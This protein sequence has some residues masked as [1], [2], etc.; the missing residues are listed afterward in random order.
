M[1]KNN[2]SYPLSGAG[3][4]WFLGKQ[5]ALRLCHIGIVLLGITFLSFSLLHMAPGDPAEKYLTGGDG[6]V[7]LISEEAIQA[8]R[9]KWGLD[10]PFLVQ[11][12]T[13]LGNALRG[14]L[15]ESFA[16]GNPVVTELWD[17]I[18][19]TVILALASLFVTLLVS[20]PLGVLCAVYKDR[21]L[22]N[23][24][25]V[26]SFVGISVPSFL[27]SLLLLYFFAMKLQWFPVISRGG[28][29][30]LVLPVAVLAFQCSAK[31]TRQV[32][33][34]VLEQL[35]QEYV[36]GAVARGV[37]KSRILFDH[38]LRNAW[39]PIVTWAGIYFGVFLGGAAVVETVFSWQGIGQLAVE[40]VASKDYQMIQ[41][42]VLWMAVLYLAVNFLVDISYTFLDP[43]VRLGKR[44]DRL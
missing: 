16:T 33:A 19:P 2:V 41:G 28:I 3:K 8:Q 39:L 42:I 1:R 30:G 10:K 29:Q 15:G 11:Y 6:N 27:S 35:H 13:W 5:A 34:V 32:R 23:I 12:V 38:V 14:D 20:I 40:S 37:K 25:R 22:D 43:R 7:G 44:G 17:K 31:F 21:L 4:A 9:E 18:G 26:V 24:C 36:R